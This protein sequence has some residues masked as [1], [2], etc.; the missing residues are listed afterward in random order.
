MDEEINQIWIGS[1]F[2]F[3]RNY[4]K[5]F[6]S[7]HAAVACGS[8]RIAPPMRSEGIRPFFASL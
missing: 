1:P 4:L 8:K 7:S 2:N 5:A 3:D 6:D